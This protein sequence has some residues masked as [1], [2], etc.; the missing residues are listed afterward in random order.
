RLRA[1]GFEN[2]RPTSDITKETMTSK[3]SPP[4]TNTFDLSIRAHPT[5]DLLG[6]PSATWPPAHRGLTGGS[7]VSPIHHHSPSPLFSIVAPY[8]L[9]LDKGSKIESQGGRLVCTK[10]LGP[11]H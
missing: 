5:D 1:A 8:H 11:R 3:A 9:H 4:G 10:P 7:T 6:R 2:W